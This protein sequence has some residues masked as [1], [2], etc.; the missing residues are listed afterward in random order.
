MLSSN[1]TNGNPELPAT[2]ANN[3]TTTPGTATN[4]HRSKITAQ[5]PES[6]KTSHPDPHQKDGQPNNPNTT[7]LNHTAQ[8]TSN[9]DGT[10]RNRHAKSTDG[11]KGQ[12]KKLKSTQNSSK[13][14]SS[15]LSRQQH[16]MD[17]ATIATVTY[18][19]DN[20]H[21]AHPK[22]ADPSITKDVLHKRIVEIKCSQRAQKISRNQKNELKKAYYIGRGSLSKR[23]SGRQRQAQWLDLIIT[24]PYARQI[25]HELTEEVS[26]C[27]HI[28][29]KVQ[30]I[31]Q[32]INH[33]Q[34]IFDATKGNPGSALGLT[35]VEGKTYGTT[36]PQKK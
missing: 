6:I 21:P 17:Q 1:E 10:K 34:Q 8:P 25:A 22:Y 9:Q 15:F 28:S 13:T 36:K 35:K 5:T 26:N 29:H 14:S 31:Q 27:H 3:S 4:L 32:L 24:G 18:A 16:E 33:S 19:W 23:I 2:D 30:H 11:N 12:S 20:R 7:K